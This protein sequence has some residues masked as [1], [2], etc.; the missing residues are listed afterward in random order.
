M[1]L[2]AFHVLFENVSFSDHY[3]KLNIKR[4]RSVLHLNLKH[5]RMIKQEMEKLV[6]RVH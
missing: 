4:V 3:G 1:L 5:S 2:L 6:M